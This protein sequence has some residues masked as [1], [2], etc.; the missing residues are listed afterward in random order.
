MLRSVASLGFV[1]SADVSLITVRLEGGHHSLYAVRS[2]LS[3]DHLLDIQQM[4][5]PRIGCHRG[6]R[7]ARHTIPLAETCGKYLTLQSCFK[8]AV[9]GPLDFLGFGL[10]STS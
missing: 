3:Q 2:L 9:I 10:N 4:S 1:R 5:S 8:P 6:K 7:P